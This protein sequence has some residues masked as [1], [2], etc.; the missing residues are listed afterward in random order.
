VDHLAGAGLVERRASFD[1]P[2]GQAIAA[3]PRQAHQVDILGIVAVPQ[4]AHQPAKRRC[5]HG[6]VEQF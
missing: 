6:I 2:V 4:M 3:E 1:N 5:G